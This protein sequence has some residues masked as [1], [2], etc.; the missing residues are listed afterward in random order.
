MGTRFG[1]MQTREKSLQKVSAKIFE[2]KTVFTSTTKYNILRK[3]YLHLKLI[4]SFN[5]GHLK[6]LI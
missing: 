4:Y 2:K 1:L 6:I 5:L 3:D